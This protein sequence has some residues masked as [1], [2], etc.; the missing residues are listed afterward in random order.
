MCVTCGIFCIFSLHVLI[1]DINYIKIV[2]EWSLMSFFK[3][4]RSKSIFEIALGSRAF[5]FLTFLT[6]IKNFSQKCILTIFIIKKSKNY[7]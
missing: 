7:F 3:V 6:S 1:K 4:W 5:N 2:V